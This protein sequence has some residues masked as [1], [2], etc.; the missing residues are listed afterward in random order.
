MARELTWYDMQ[1]LKRKTH[2]VELSAM[3]CLSRPPGSFGADQIHLRVNLL[4][5]KQTIDELVA[6]FPDPNKKANPS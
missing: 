3:E 2:A 1:A 6:Q 4:D 5:L